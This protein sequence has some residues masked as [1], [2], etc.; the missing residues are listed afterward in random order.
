VPV[1]RPGDTHTL[2]AEM[3]AADLA[4]FVDDALVWKG[5]VGPEVLALNGPVGVRSDNARLELELRA[6][7]LEG[8]H[9]NYVRGCKAG[10]GE[11]D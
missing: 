9:P 10:S 3:K 2:R 8:V 5:N 4:V 1:V 7:Q 6:M 11:S